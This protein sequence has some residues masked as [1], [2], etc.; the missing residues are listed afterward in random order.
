MK[1]ITLNNRTAFVVQSESFQTVAE[2]FTNDIPVPVLHT[3]RT[4][5]RQAYDQEI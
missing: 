1:L 2:D 3:G 4:S 5:R